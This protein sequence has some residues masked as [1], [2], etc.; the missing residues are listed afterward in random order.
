MGL[1]LDVSLY[2]RPSSLALVLTLTL[3]ACLESFV[4]QDTKFVGPSGGHYGD[5]LQG[6]PTYLRVLSQSI[7]NK[8]TLEVMDGSILLF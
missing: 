3:T 4:F 6:F 7:S 2:S 1:V 8:G 5:L